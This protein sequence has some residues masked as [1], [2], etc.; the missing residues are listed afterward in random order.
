MSEGYSA[1]SPQLD[2]VRPGP[3]AAPVH[4]FWWNAWL[5]VKVVQARLRFFVLLGVVGAVIASWSTLAAYY[6][7]WTRPLY[8]QATAPDPNVE[9]YC[10]MHR[11]IVRDNRKEKCP[12]CHMELAKRKKASEADERLPPGIVERVQLTPYR[13]VLAG[14]LTDEVRPRRLSKT[15]AAFGSVEFNE[16]KQAH[17]AARQKAR[18]VKLF[19]NYTGQDVKKGDPLAVLDF[20]YSP[21]LNVTFEDLQRARRG[22]DKEAEQMAR[23]RLQ[24]WDVGPEQ[25]EDFFRTGKMNTELT[26]TSP[27]SGHVTRKYQR[28]G[29]FVEEGTPLFDVDDLE[30]V[31]IEAQIYEADLGLLEKG[32]PVRATTEAFPNEVFAGTL[33]FLYPHLD[34]N[35]RT[36]TVRFD[37]PNPGHKLRPGMYATVTI[38]AE[39]DRVGSLVRAAAEDV[40]AVAAIESLARGPGVS[41]LLYGASRRAALVEGL[42]PSVPDSAVIDTGDRK[43]VYREAKPDLFEGVE[44]ALGPRMAEPGSST[45][46]YPV[47]RGL[48]AGDRVVVNG[49]FLIDAQ[50]R[51]N[52][53][54]GSIYYGGSGAKTAGSSGVAVRPSTPPNAE[55]KQKAPAK[56]EGHGHD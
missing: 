39:P 1:D 23:R 53:S 56:V 18:I 54:A 33:D 8:A 16:A 43:V 5:V 44:V 28:E 13:V 4:G 12:I 40:A 50:T 41:A 14:A 27:I 9:Y 34:E 51:L 48:G 38:D 26:I 10:P 17:I 55:E 45:A 7:K 6:E 46:F 37:I 42:L 15:I 31:W 19:V 11:E 49:A 30:K 3:P 21:E 32:L 24:L 2:G 20:R 35:S 52:P 36:L 47:L 22:G 29:A 25:I